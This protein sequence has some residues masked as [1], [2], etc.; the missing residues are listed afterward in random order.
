MKRREFLATLTMA[1]A[2]SFVPWQGAQADDAALLGFLRTNWS[3]DPYSLGAYSYVAKNA[4]QNDRIILG[5]PINGRVYFAGE[6]VHPTQNSTVHA[7]YESGISTALV[8]GRSSAERV[9]II[10]AGISGLAAAKALSDNGKSVSVF[11]ARNRIGGRIWTE[12]SLGV[13]LDLGASWIHGTRGNPLTKLAHEASAQ[14]VATDENYIIRGVKGRHIKEEDAPDWLENVISIQHDAGADTSEINLRAYMGEDEYSGEDVIFPTGYESILG[15]LR[16]NYTIHVSEKVSGISYNASGVE[17]VSASAKSTFDAV[18]V[19]LPLG[20]LKREVVTFR[21][22]LP[23][24]KRQAIKRLGMGT[25]DKLC[26]LFDRPFWDKDITWIITPDNGLPKGQFNQWLN[27]YKYLN[28]P[29][30]IGFNG[31]PPAIELSAMSDESIVE[32]AVASLRNSY[33]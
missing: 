26:L 6:A 4:N 12:N 20:V 22:A 23:Q 19:T 2:G 8:V 28:R 7:A 29:I 9:G 15:A 11:E 14:T 3:R 21:P 25:L 17:V 10:G 16:G 18:I 32:M 24:A 5:A 31:G 13:P 1:T 33:S 30:V 27:L